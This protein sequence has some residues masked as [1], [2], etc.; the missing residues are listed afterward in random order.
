MT[1]G[2]PSLP[3]AGAPARASA[4]RIVLLPVLL[5]LGGGAIALG[6]LLWSD[7]DA[8]QRT[9]VAVDA[10]DHLSVARR[11]V[12]LAYLAAD[13]RDAGDPAFGVAPAHALLDRAMLALEDWREGRPTR[14]TSG[15]GRPADSAL[16]VPLES[17]RLALVDLDPFLHDGASPAA[18]RNAFARAERRADALETAVDQQVRALERERSALILLQVAVLSMLLLAA[19]AGMSWLLL[20]RARSRERDAV[21]AAA[22]QQAQK[23]EAIGTLAGGVAHDFNNVLAAM[24]GHLEL[25]RE[26]PERATRT[27]HLENVRQGID[28][29]AGLV[30]QILAFSRRADGI[31]QPVSLRQAAHDA[32]RL[33]RASLPPDVTLVLRDGPTRGAEADA[34]PRTTGNPADAG[35]DTV[36]ADP[37][38]LQQILMNLVI[39]A[40]QA[41]EG[42]GTVTVAVERV[43]APAGSDPQHD[44]WLQLEVADDGPGI[45]PDVLPRIFEPF[46][47]TKAAGQGTGLG[48]S[49][50]HGI[51]TAHGGR[52]GVTSHP[53]EGARFQ[54]LLPAVATPSASQRAHAH[55]TTP[56]LP[57]RILLVDDEPGILSSLSRALARMGHTVHAFGDA[58]EALDAIGSRE[59]DVLLTDL[60]MPH[61][62]GRH[63]IAAM[64]RAQPSAACVL[65]T[66]YGDTQPA[67]Q[68]D[69]T[70]LGKPFAIS[71]L[72]AILARTGD[73]GA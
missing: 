69:V 68:D 41:V 51:V 21:R 49:V 35:V 28:R 31:R 44:A 29:A 67:R 22:L 48:L 15:T 50:V 63:L 13:R 38:Q 10:I 52:I 2:A 62:D 16:R 64:R 58:R 57:L 36:L 14:T 32:T 45:P 34:A 37:A 70:V 25:A 47:T 4:L 3:P 61:H 17:Y 46:F 26:S 11:H 33:L 42:R 12:A 24:L 55:D 40:A 19:G 39:N 65:M 7:R 18:R 30:R 60:S 71:E 43:A 27:E 59:A 9:T 53:G 8:R 72:A 5:L 73:R 20:A 23:L 1:T 56:T 6:V 54:V 66:G